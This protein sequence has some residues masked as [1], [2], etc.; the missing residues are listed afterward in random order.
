MQ[1]KPCPAGIA[2]DR[3]MAIFVKA[4]VLSSRQQ[5]S[6]PRMGPCMSYVPFFV[7][8]SVPIFLCITLDTNLQC[9]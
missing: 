4:W 9:L 7:T 3:Q 8:L 2:H 6:V 1:L 5:Y